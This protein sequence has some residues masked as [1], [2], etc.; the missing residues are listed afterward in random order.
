M[1]LATDLY[2]GSLPPDDPIY[3]SGF[4]IG[5]QQP[6]ESLSDSQQA[7]I[8]AKSEGE[9]AQQIIQNRLK[10]HDKGSGL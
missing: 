10:R 2:K 6:A 9:K 8:P 7:A 5:K 1:P 3:R 4:V